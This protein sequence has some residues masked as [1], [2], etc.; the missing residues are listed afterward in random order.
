MTYSKSHILALC[1]TV[2]VIGSIS[3]SF[4]KYV[5]LKDYH[6]YMEVPC[7]P[8]AESCFVY[9]CDSEIDDDCTYEENQTYYKFISKKA[10][11]MPGCDPN[12]VGCEYPTCENDEVCEEIECV[13]VGLGAGEMCDVL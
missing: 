2:L 13:S 7:N 11:L 8:V 5:I 3:I 9:T 1:A 4:Y 6:I 10:Y 12:D